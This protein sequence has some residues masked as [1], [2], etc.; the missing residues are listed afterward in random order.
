MGGAYVQLISQ[1]ILPIIVTNFGGNDIL[2]LPNGGAQINQL[3]V[4]NPY[5]IINGSSQLFFPASSVQLYS[6]IP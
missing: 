2:V 5:T 4:N 1:N 3:G 6:L